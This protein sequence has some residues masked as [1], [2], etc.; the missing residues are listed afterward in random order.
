MNSRLHSRCAILYQRKKASR[1][2][3]KVD[4]HQFAYKVE[5]I[6]ACDLEGDA[7]MVRVAHLGSYFFEIRFNTVPRQTLQVKNK[8]LWQD[9]VPLRGETRKAMM[10]KIDEL[11]T[12][13]GV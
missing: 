7:M 12:L 5:P 11:L 2:L 8:T 9:G 13:N 4:T 10:A 6:M 3:R 1:K